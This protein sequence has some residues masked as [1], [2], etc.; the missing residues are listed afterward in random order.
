MGRFSP[1]FI[2]GCTYTMCNMQTVKKHPLPGDCGHWEMRVRQGINFC[3]AAGAL[4]NFVESFGTF[5]TDRLHPELEFQ[6]STV[7]S[8]LNLTSKYIKIETYHL[9]FI[10]LLL[11]MHML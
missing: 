11:N 5:N 10:L 4:K 2:H 7:Q 8:F 1:T 6:L 3:K 9:T